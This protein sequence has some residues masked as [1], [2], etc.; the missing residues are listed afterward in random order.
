M[1]HVKSLGNSIKIPIKPD[2]EGYIGRECPNPEC[3]GYFKI[4]PGTG[5]HNITSCY[6]PY[7]GH[8][9]EQKSFWTKDQIEYVKSYALSK[10]MDAVRK[11]MKELEFDIKPK[12]PFGIG[13]SMKFKEGS[14]VPVRCYREK[15][16]ETKIICDNC[17]LSYAIY[18]VFAFCPDCGTH[19]SKQI[20]YK[21]LE[22][23]EKEIALALN[24]EMELSDHLIADALENAVS[25]F[26]GFGRETCKTHASISS[27]PDKAKKMSFQNLFRARQR[28]QELFCFDLALGFEPKD[29]DFALRCFQKRH[30][31]A[32]KMGVIDEEYVIATNDPEAVVGRKVSIKPEE[33]ISLI[34]VLKKLGSYFVMQLSDRSS[35]INSSEDRMHE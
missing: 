20:L 22:L 35:S 6:C 18:G 25:S 31:L 12:G 4:T 14:P 32:H 27:N 13:F 8:F 23:A 16:L 28:V 5:L 24:L 21:N 33:V 2:E 19:N 15:E 10:I 34:E 3:E 26:D 7:C 1:S 9:A 11:D 29:W 30:L 17:T